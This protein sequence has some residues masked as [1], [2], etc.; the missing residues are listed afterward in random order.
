MARLYAATGDAIARLDETDGAW[1]TTL[2]LTGSG[3]QCLAL[4][5]SDPDTVYAGLREGGI[6]R[7]TDGGSSWTQIS[8]RN[9]GQRVWKTQPEG[10]FVALGIS[11]SRRMRVR[12]SPSRFGTAERSASV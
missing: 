11:P 10:G 9:R 7:T 4:D 6:R 8:P 1:Q 3:A 2:S 5:P 12:S